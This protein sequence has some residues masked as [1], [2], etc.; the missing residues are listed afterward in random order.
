[1]ASCFLGV[2]RHQGLEF[3]FGLFVFEMSRS[4]SAEHAGEFRPGVGATHID[5]THR[6]NARLGRFDAEEVRG[7]AALDAA[8]EFPLRRDDQML[9]E[10]IRMGRDLDP[11]ATASDHREHRAP[12][13]NHP[14]IV[15]QLRH[16]LLDR[17]LFR[18][19][20][21]QHEF[22]LEYGAAALHPSIEG[23][24]HPVQ[25]RM[26]DMALNI[27]KDLPGIRFVPAPVQV[28]GHQAKL[29]DEIAGEVFWLD[30]PA[31]FPPQPQ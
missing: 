16:V 24:P 7:L 2:L 19:L 9:V 26:P 21:R 11:L 6:L 25:Y 30:F 1:M 28:F 18:E 17:R 31:F 8:P 12:R 23:S 29:N 15:L 13:R 3:G 10:R 27:G 5:D 20:P 14:H 22:G 4:C